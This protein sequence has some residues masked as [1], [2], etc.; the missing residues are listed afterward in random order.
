MNAFILILPILLIRF[1]PL[2]FVSKQALQRA[3][4]FPPV[5]GIEKAAFWVY[6]LTV[7]IMFIYL[8]FLNLRLR[9]IVNYLGLGI[10]LIGFILYAISFLDY[11]KPNEN[12]INK[13]G[14]Y[15][16]SRNPMYVAFFLYFFGSSLLTNSWPFFVILIIFQIS[17]H[18]LILSE[19][20]WCS[21]EFGEEYQDYM[22]EVRRYI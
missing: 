6:Q 2:K 4:Y 10:Y 14:L 16:F 19:E 8:F 1:A 7:T 3:R 9:T 20:R 15:Q 5:E 22:K 11:A 12:G 17:V 21:K 13:T 18:F